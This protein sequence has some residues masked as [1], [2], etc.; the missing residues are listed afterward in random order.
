MNSVQCYDFFGGNST[1]RKITFFI[2]LYIIC[3]VV[4]LNALNCKVS[5][6]KIIA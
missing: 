2:W 6:I 3:K 5:I 1:F 4:Y